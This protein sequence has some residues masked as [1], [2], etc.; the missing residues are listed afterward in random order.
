MKVLFSM[1]VCTRKQKNGPSSTDQAHSIAKAVQKQP[2]PPPPPPPQETDDPKAPVKAKRAW[3]KPVI[4]RMSYINVT[5]SGPD[6]QAP[7]TEERAKYRPA[8]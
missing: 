1:P 4:R 6:V 7:D 5:I 2:P 8:S 3:S